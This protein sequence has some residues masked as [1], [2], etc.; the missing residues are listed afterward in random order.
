[1][2]QK[3]GLQIHFLSQLAIWNLTQLPSTYVM[4][5]KMLPHCYRAAFQKQADNT[6][7]RKYG[8]TGLGLAI[9]KSL[10][11]LMGGNLSVTSKAGKSSRFTI[12]LQLPT[13]EDLITP[14]LEALNIAGSNILI[15]DD[16]IINRNILKE[17]L[18]HWKW[19]LTS[20]E[21]A[22]RL[23]LPVYIAAVS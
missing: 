6:T 8:G 4:L 1:M 11:T 19:P 22:W 3:Y 12:Q 14:T 5:S 13:H 10:V 9:A 18:A 23:L 16:N 7:T 15:I 20:V 21:L 2:G 17:Q